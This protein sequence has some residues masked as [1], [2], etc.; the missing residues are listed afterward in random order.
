MATRTVPEQRVAHRMASYAQVGA[1]TIVAALVAVGIVRLLAGWAVTLDPT[2]QPTE[3]GAIIPATAFAAAAASAVFWLVTRFTDHPVRYFVTLA[4]V[5]LV[6]GT[7][8]L[9]ALPLPGETLA[10]LVTALAMHVAAAVAI[11]GFLILKAP[12]D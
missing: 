6:V 11:V 10:G 2:Y 3:W 1:W 4:A 9:F 7:V 12:I 5:V 8:P